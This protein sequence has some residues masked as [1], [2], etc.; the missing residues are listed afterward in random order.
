MHISPRS[1][2]KPPQNWE[3]YQC[4]YTWTLHPA[5]G[6]QSAFHS[7]SNSCDAVTSERWKSAANGA[8]C[9]ANKA[10]LWGNVQ[11]T[12]TWRSPNGSSVTRKQTRFLDRCGSLRKITKADEWERERKSEKSFMRI[13]VWSDRRKLSLFLFHSRCISDRGRKHRD[14]CLQCFWIY[15]AWIHQAFRLPV[16]AE[17]EKGVFV[18]LLVSEYRPHTHMHFQATTCTRRQVFTKC[19]KSDTIWLQNGKK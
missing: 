1:T 6:R 17:T 7:V 19:Y 3:C 8:I 15:R 12:S 2:V 13:F 4:K 5:L 18:A 11:G 9:H 10:R 16:D 14:T